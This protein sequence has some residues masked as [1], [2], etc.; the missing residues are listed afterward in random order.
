MQDGRRGNPVLLA[1]TLFDRAMRLDGDEGARRLLA[2]LSAGE[3]IEIDAEGSGAAFD[4]DTP[5][6]LSLIGRI[7]R[8]DAKEGPN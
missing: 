1:R 3:I 8:D 2:D 5:G 7:L 4:V 6:D